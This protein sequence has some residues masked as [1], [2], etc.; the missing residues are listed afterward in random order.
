MRKC[1]R[2]DD[3]DDEDDDDDDDGDVEDNEGDDN[4][5]NAMASMQWRRR[6]A[7]GHR[8]PP[9]QGSFQ[10]SEWQLISETDEAKAER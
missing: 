8:W 1:N 5:V 4:G 10:M 9:E 7:N 6:C 2:N 3:D